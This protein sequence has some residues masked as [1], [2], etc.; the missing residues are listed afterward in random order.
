M[1]AKVRIL[2]GRGNQPCT[3]HDWQQPWPTAVVRH[4]AQ[5]GAWMVPPLSRGLP[6][7]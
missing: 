3:K 7:R 1:T 6:D 2:K 5:C 4:C